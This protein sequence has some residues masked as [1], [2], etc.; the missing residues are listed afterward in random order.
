MIYPHDLSVLEARKLYFSNS[1]FDD[2][3]YTDRWAKLPILWFHIYL[4]NFAGRRHAVPLHDI[5]HILTE[6]KTDW[7]GEWQI[8]AYEIGTGCG[9]YW[10]G[11]LINLQG[12]IAGAF[13]APKKSVQAFARGRRSKGIYHFMDH[14]P[15]LLENVGALRKSTTVSDEAVVPRVSDAIL[16]YLIVLMSITAHLAPFVLLFLF[17]TSIA[18]K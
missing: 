3:T 5:N 1:G 9:R 10:A 14:K 8:G 15:L 11:W 12:I 4:P 17:A 18:F 13:I 2:R 16:F 7:L 6:Y